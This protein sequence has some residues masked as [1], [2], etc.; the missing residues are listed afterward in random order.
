M[1]GCIQWLADG[2]GFR[3][4]FETKWEPPIYFRE[5]P[6]YASA[7]IALDVCSSTESEQI[8]A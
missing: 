7:Q 5:A 4:L 6:K 3:K 2:R 1:I 8:F